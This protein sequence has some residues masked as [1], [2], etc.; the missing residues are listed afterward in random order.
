MDAKPKNLKR[1]KT[2]RFDTKTKVQK[3]NIMDGRKSPSTNKATKVWMKCLNDYLKEKEL[4]DADTI[5]IEELPNVLSDFYTELR[6]ADSSGEYKTSTLKCIR[7]AINRHF[8]VTRSL[9]I[10]SDP[11]FIL[12]NEMFSG[13]A[14]KAKAE[15]RG[16]TDSRPAIEEDMKKISAYFTEH[17][18]GPPNPQKLLEMALFSIIY[19]MCRRGRQNL[20]TMTKDTFKIDTDAN[21]Q[22]YIY[23]AVKE[24]DK[25]HRNEDMTS[26]NQARIYEQPGNNKI[27]KETKLKT[28]CNW[29]FCVTQNDLFLQILRFVQ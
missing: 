25:N 17:L 23:Q 13:V 8:K 3:Q 4:P 10:I 19:Y 14:K 15:G 9:D 6:K 21:G 12:S 20:R 1:K 18:N 2:V 22:K 29:L 11:C 26:N 16:E 27:L 5:D 7:A 24:H 28:K